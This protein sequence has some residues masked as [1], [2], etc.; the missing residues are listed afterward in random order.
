VH[1]FNPLASTH[2]GRKTREAEGHSQTSGRDESLAPS[3]EKSVTSA[4]A[5]FVSFP[6]RRESGA[7]PVPSLG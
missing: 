6:R 2:G 1:K 5:I 7:H 3:R 4:F